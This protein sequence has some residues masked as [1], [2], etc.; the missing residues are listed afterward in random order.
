MQRDFAW[1]VTIDVV[2]TRRVGKDMPPEHVSRCVFSVED[3]RALSLEE[4]LRSILK[5]L[6]DK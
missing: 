5:D 6:G 2:Q 1:S 3:D 4:A